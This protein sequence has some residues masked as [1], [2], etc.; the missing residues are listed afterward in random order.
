MCPFGPLTLVQRGGGDREKE[1]TIYNLVYEGKL[2][3]SPKFIFKDN[4]CMYL[5]AVNP[6][7]AGDTNP[8][9]APVRWGRVLWRATYI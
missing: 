8:A 7:S 6:Y 5:Q 3:L 9:M 1:A 2:L 4:L